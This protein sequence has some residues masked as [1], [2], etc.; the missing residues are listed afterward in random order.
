MLLYHFESR[1]KLLALIID[2]IREQLRLFLTAQAATDEKLS[3]GLRTLWSL[4]SRPAQTMCSASWSRREP[5]AYM[6]GLAQLLQ[7]YAQGKVRPCVEAPLPLAKL[8][9]AYARMGGRAVMGK[10]VL[11]P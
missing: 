3:T 1:E 4:A 5:K 2:T 11:V 9:E 10:V 8:H 6:Q 7:W